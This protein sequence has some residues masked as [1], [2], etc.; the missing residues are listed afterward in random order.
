MCVSTVAPP[1]DAMTLKHRLVQKGVTAE[2]CLKKIN[3]YNLTPSEAERA[4]HAARSTKIPSKLHGAAKL[5]TSV[6]RNVTKPFFPSV[7][8]RPGLVIL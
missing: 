6:L 1:K 4:R 3:L 5:S 2:K 8:S 7:Y